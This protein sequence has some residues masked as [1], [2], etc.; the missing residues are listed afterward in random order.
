M[1]RRQILWLVPAAIWL[2]FTFWYTDFGGPL[3][4]EEISAGLEKFQSQGY[5]PEQ[6]AALAAFLRND[7]GKQFLMVN[8]IDMDDNP[9][10][11]PDYGP[12]ATASDYFDYYLDH[13]YTQLFRRASHP[14]FAGSAL[15]YTADEFGVGSDAAFGWDSAALMRYR[16]RR[17]FLGVFTHPETR[18]RYQYKVAAMVKTIAYPVEPALYLSDI[19]LLLFLV[20]GLVTALVDIFIYG[21]QRQRSNQ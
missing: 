3:S 17:S 1:T 14:A 2:V 20:L 11:M 5:T 21:R 18:N 8:N 15:N 7:T 13:I 16:S 6:V 19:R 9:P 4:E 10:Q 12:D